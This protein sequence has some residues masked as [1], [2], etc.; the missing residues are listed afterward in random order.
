MKNYMKT[1]TNKN[2]SNNSNSKAIIPLS[3]IVESKQSPLPKRFN[4]HHDSL[5]FSITT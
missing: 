1:I 3:N 5:I 2:S 4:K